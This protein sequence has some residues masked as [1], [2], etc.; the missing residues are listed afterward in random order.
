MVDVI[1]KNLLSSAWGKNFIVWIFSLFVAG[2]MA[3]SWFC[4]HMVN[5]L[6]A[7]NEVC[8]QQS[9]EYGHER[10]KLI[11]GHMSDLRAFGE[12]VAQ[13]EQQIKQ[14]RK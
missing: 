11:E 12:R 14:R 7:C 5:E 6:K 9:M 13:I 2:I 3:L 10:Q 8:Q 1:L 4:L